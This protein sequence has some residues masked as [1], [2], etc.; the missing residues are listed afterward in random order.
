M[1]ANHLLT[2][3][4]L[5]SCLKS[6]WMA[7]QDGTRLYYVLFNSNGGELAMKVPR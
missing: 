5:T 1:T 2:T 4:K 6:R 7:Q 3:S